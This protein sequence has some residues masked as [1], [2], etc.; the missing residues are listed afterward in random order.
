MALVTVVSGA[1]AKASDVQQLI[2]LLTGVMTDQPVYIANTI[3]AQSTGATAAAYFAGGTASGA[4]TTGT[5]NAGE[6]IL[7]QSG[8]FWICTV[9]GTPGTWKQA[10]S[11]DTVAGDY[12]SLVAAGAATIAGATGKPADAGHQHNAKVNAASGFTGNLFHGQLN[13]VDKFT[14][15]QTGAI[16]AAS[17]GSFA[18]LSITG[19]GLLGSAQAAAAAWYATGARAEARQLFTA[20]S[21]PAADT[22]VLEG[23]ILFN[24]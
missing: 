9:T 12:L 11:V 4:P 17:A 7:D 21:R 23:D 15:D 3:R 5:H 18:G 19:S 8:S 6:F 13:G 1:A 2:N 14:V 10:G 24:A 20:N 22:G 16:V